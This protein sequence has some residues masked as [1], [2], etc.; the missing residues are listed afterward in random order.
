MTKILLSQ[1]YPEIGSQGV[2]LHNQSVPRGTE[3]SFTD[4]TV[5]AACELESGPLGNNTESSSP[6]LHANSHET[7]TRWAF[8][9]DR[10]AKK[11]VIR[12]V[13]LKA[14]GWLDKEVKLADF[15]EYNKLPRVVK[16]TRHRC[17]SDRDVALMQQ[18]DTGNAFYAGSHT[19]GSAWLCPTCSAKIEAR[20]RTEIEQIIQHKMSCGK[21]PVF[22]TFTIPHTDQQSCQEVFDNIRNALTYLRS[23]KA[24]QKFKG[25]VGFDGL[26]R[27]LEV[28]LGANGW[29][30]HTHE[31]W[32]VDDD[33][34][35]QDFYQFVQDRWT[36]A[37]DKYGLIPRGKRRSFRTHGFT[38]GFTRSEYLAKFDNQKYI[39]KLSAEVS[40]SG[41]KHGRNGS[42]HPFQLAELA[43]NNGSFDTKAV[44]LFTEYL[45]T[46]KGKARVY[47]S[48]GLKDECGIN[49]LTDEEIA[50]Q[51][52]EEATTICHFDPFAFRLIVDKHAQ[53]VIQNLAEHRG[54]EGVLAWFEPYDEDPY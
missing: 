17:R 38:I 30:I 20:R 43:F 21:K 11:T 44:D 28:T 36:K 25:R 5:G 27:S 39:G 41:V 3:P 26:V 6:P 49:E 16:C 23:G 29:H 9:L 14:N 8:R 54:L 32:F 4:C 2:S 12:N 42:L 19:C 53:G 10:Y 52:K 7:L 48:P 33:Y 40:L 47:F 24:W 37:C 51:E 22:S 50:T 15:E 13:I 46:F 45:T 18:V 35:E 31:L 1:R 34:P